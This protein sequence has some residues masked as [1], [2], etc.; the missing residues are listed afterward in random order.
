MMR[1]L[2]EELLRMWYQKYFHSIVRRGEIT[3]WWAGVYREVW[4]EGFHCMLAPFNLFARIGY[5]FWLW[6][7]RPIKYF[8]AAMEVEYLRRIVKEQKLSGGL[9]TLKSK[10]DDS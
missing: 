3:V 8:D 2:M 6:L 9:E 10:R 7:R 4:G 1:D 5:N